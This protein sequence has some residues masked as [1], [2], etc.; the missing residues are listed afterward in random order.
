[1][2]VESKVK[3]V[4][5][6]AVNNRWVFE[7]DFPKLG[8]FNRRGPLWHHVHGI[9][10]HGDQLRGALAFVSGLQGGGVGYSWCPQ[11]GTGQLWAGTYFGVV[12]VGVPGV[13]RQGGLLLPPSKFSC[14]AKKEEVVG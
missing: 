6:K 4:G 14:R 2:R 11:G 3:G 9:N 12:G 7:Q 8:L 5:Q 1:M 10:R 13:L